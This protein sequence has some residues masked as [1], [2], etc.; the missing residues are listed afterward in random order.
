MHAGG[1]GA[2]AR[3]LLPRLARGGLGLARRSLRR[4]QE[5]RQALASRGSRL[6]HSRLALR[7]GIGQHDVTLG[8]SG[9]RGGCSARLGRGQGGG[10]SLRLLRRGGA[11]VC[12][13]SSSSGSLGARSR[14]L[15]GRGVQ[16]G[17]LG[18]QSGGSLRLGSG[19]RIGGCSFDCGGGISLSL[20]QRCERLRLGGSARL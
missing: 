16:L 19:A 1:V 6:S 14:Q 10:G 3:Q 7:G 18:G 9:G 2:R 12:E 15:P 4:G 5:R 20:C 8:R 11:R 17:S 13:R